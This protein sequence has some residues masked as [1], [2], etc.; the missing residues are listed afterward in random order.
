MN[1]LEVQKQDAAAIRWLHGGISKDDS[2]PVL[3]GLSVKNGITVTTDGW[4]LRIAPTPESLKNLDTELIELEK[5]PRA[6]GDMVKTF[7]VDGDYPDWSGVIP[8]GEPV[9]QIT[10]NAELL[11]SLVKDMG[12]TKINPSI[13]LSFYSPTKPIIFKSADKFALLMP[14]HSADGQK[15]FDPINQPVP[16]D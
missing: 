15:L 11:A 10:L 12:E 1:Y 3:Q 14:M 7:N 4:Q 16:E 6:G 2:R 13:E 9:F 8:S 5:A